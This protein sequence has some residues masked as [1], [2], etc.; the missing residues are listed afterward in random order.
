MGGFAVSRVSGFGPGCWLLHKIIARLMKRL[1]RRCVLVEEQGSSYL[2]DGDGDGNSDSDD[3]RVPRPLQA[4]ACTG[5]IVFG[6]AYR[7]EGVHGA[8]R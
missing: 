6:P 8:R 5:R 2:V 4:A 1:T 7:A 3:A